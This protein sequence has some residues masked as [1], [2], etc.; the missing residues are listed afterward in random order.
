MFKQLQSLYRFINLWF[1]RMEELFLCLMLATM[2]GV[3]CLQI[4]LRFFSSGGGFLWI[5]PLLRYLVLWTGLFGAAAV[6]GRGKH[7]AL[8]IISYLLP[9]KYHPWL[10]TVI[11]LFSAA[12]CGILTWAAVIFIRNEAEFGSRILLSIPS[13]VWNLAFPVAFALI[14]LR[15]LIATVTESPFFAEAKTLPKTPF[16]TE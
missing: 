7:I 1:S 3:A 4:M 13:W 5:D 12:V 10:R 2:I 15:F 8:D 9:P 11:N 16:P 6:T 14:T